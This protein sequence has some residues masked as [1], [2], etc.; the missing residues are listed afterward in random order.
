MVADIEHKLAECRA[1]RDRAMAQQTATSEILRIINSSPDLAPVF[2][3]ILDNALHLCEA[4]F[5]FVTD[6]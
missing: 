6:V 1:E 2:I 5:R 3:A 4:A